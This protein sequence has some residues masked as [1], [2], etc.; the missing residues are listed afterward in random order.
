MIGK[1]LSVL[2]RIE[3]VITNFRDISPDK[4][5]MNKWEINVPNIFLGP[6]AYVTDSL[7]TSN[8]CD[9]IKEQRFSKAYIAAAATK[10][11]E[12]FT[13]QWRVYIVCYFANLVKDLEG[14]FVECG[15]NTGAYSR[16][17][18]E[19]VD[20]Q[21]LSKQFFLFDTFSG[22]D[23]SQLIDQEKEI[24][25]DKMYGKNYQDVYEQVK[26]T[27]RDFNV[28]VV[29]GLV[30]DTLHLCKS[31]KICYLS[32]DMN[33]TTPEIAAAHYFWDKVVSGGVVL[34]DD[35]G[36]PPH[37]SQKHAFDL[38][39]KEKGVEILSL[40]TGQGIIIKP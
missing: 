19:Y 17:V 20:F 38:F 24:G 4:K 31:E 11:W 6:I 26:E 28:T 21:S 32:I 40:P 10:P 39:A 13:L 2:R 29:K 3:W 37:I 15:V 27:F 12:G 16:A 5:L 22:L 36:F 1:I 30:P 25:I 33:V 34:L 14:D 18:I 8:N 35:Y 7:V 9:F 23:F